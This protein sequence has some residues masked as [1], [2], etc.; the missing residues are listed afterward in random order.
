MT[1]KKTQPNLEHHWLNLP[2][3]WNTYEGFIYEIKNKKTN[4]KYIGRKY[5]WVQKKTRLVG[6]SKW[7]FYTSSSKKVNMLIQEQGK[8]TFEFTIL[9]VHRTRAATNYAEVEA[10][11]MAKVLTA[12]L[13]NGEPEYYND[14]I[15]SHYFRQKDFGTPEYYQRCQNLSIALKRAY[16]NGLK[17]ST[18]VF[19]PGSQVNK[20]RVCSEETKLKISEARKGKNMGNKNAI[21]NKVNNKCKLEK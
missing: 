7:R 14:N 1:T 15:M 3:D 19:K 18:S 16:A 4:Q 21:K 10:Q 13:Q 20:G 9:S 8:D 12:T 5:F 17:P 2:D 11:I 6:E